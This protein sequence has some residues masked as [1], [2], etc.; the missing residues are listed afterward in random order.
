MKH[1]LF[2]FSLMLV[3][4]SCDEQQVSK[5]ESLPEAVAAFK[6]SQQFKSLEST[7]TD[8]STHLSF[9][10]FWRETIGDKEVFAVPS[11]KNA[12]I[13]GVVYF[14]KNFNVIVETRSFS[15]DKVL[16]SFRDIENMELVKWTGVKR[17]ESY[18]FNYNELANN[19]T[20]PTISGKS[21]SCTG[22]CYAAAKKACESDNDCD[23]MCDLTPGCHASIA[24]ACFVHCW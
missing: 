23:M 21:A 14:D 5:Q 13:E 3:V 19:Y 12:R 17:G 11:I 20:Q 15:D 10:A 6:T 8:L 2:I 4:I 24:I 1:L 16:L 9:D 22:D 18:A 7:F